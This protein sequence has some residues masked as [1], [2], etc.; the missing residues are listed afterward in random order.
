ME[1]FAQAEVAG[2]LELLKLAVSGGSLM[3]TLVLGWYFHGRIDK[4]EVRFD[5]K[6][7]AE[8]EDCRKERENANKSF[9]GA[10]E[11]IS[12]KHSETNKE[13][14]AALMETNRTL[15]RATY[16]QEAVLSR[17]KFESL[18]EGDPSESAI[19]SANDEFEKKNPGR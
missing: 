15:A 13:S 2:M 6:L 7:L 11:K 10:I 17:L 5:A 16:V 1:F 8:H 18:G 4:Q 9:L 19:R 12:E 14:T 3:L